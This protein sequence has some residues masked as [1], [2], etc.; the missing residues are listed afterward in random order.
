M[1]LPGVLEAFGLVLARTSALVVT[2]PVLGLGA[3][4]SGYKIGLIFSLSVV[5]YAVAGVPAVSDA[6]PVFYG[7]LMLREILIGVFLGFILQ[8]VTLAVRVGGELIGHEMGFM[9]ARQVD[10]ASGISTPLVTS[11]YENLF[12]LAFL[13]LNGHHWLIRSLDESFARAPIGSL[14]VGEGFAPTIKAMFGEMFGAGIMFAAPVMVFLVLV[15]ILIGLLARAVPTLNVLEV[16]FT[17]RVMVAMGAMFLFAPLLE[18]AMTG[19]H[20]DFVAW[21]DRGLGALEG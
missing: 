3:R 10:P 18:P 17:I 1:L 4:F 19:L 9:V 20:Q 21:L 6:G 2:A 5:L 15:S 14:S 13:A 12:I 7:M 8:L 11:V 16:G